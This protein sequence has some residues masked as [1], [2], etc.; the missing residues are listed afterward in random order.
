MDCQSGC[1]HLQG[2]AGRAVGPVHWD[3]DRSELNQELE[4]FPAAPGTE[5]ADRG[6][7]NTLHSHCRPSA[8]VAHPRLPVG[9]P[10]SD[11][12]AAGMSM[13]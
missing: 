4:G 12:R 13:V 5:P 1:S 2:V 7:G 6:S 8:A 9:Q 3:S 11:T 10:D